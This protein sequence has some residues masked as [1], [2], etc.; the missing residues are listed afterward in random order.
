MQQRRS[1]DGL[2]G[3][4]EFGL[5]EPGAADLRQG[6]N[7]DGGEDEEHRQPESGCHRF[8]EAEIGPEHGAQRDKVVEQKDLAGFPAAEGIIPDRKGDTPPAM[9]Q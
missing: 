4:G 2:A 3:G 7:D 1:F 8:M 9:M 5:F 6:R